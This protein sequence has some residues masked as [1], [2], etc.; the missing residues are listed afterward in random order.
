VRTFTR[1]LTRRKRRK[2]AMKTK[3]TRRKRAIMMKTKRMR[4]RRRRRKRRCHYRFVAPLPQ[5]ILGT[6]LVKPKC[7]NIIT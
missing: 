3:R 4:R 2:G 7:K 6:N 1:K 5:A